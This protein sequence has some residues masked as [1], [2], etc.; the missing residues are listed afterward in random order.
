MVDR[1]RFEDESNCQSTLTI[2]EDNLFLDETGRMAMEGV[3]EHIAQTAA[4]HM[5]F[6]QKRAGRDICLGYIG[7]IKRCTV[8]NPMP[9]VGA[10]LQTRITV[11]SQVGDISLV[12]AQTETENGTVLSCRMKVAM[13]NPNQ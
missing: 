5:G 9:T 3:L 7:D 2:A 4:A 1:Y 10:I 11:I 13:D 6:Q 8:N 12:S